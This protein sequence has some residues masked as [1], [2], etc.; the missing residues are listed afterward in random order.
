MKVLDIFPRD[1][2]INMEFSSAE[3]HYILE[4]LK[5]AISLYAKVYSDGSTEEL[6]SAIDEFK[7]QLESILKAIKTESKNGP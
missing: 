2:Y 3:I 5:K 6:D 1:I 4:F 7:S